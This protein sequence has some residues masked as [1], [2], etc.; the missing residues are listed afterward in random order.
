VADNGKGIPK[1]I[2]ERLGERGFTH[3]K[4]GGSGLGLYHAR[5][6]FALW[7]GSLS[8]KSS[9]GRGTTVEVRLPAA[10]P[11]LWFADKVE[12]LPGQVVV[13]L[14]DDKAIHATWDKL[15]TPFVSAGGEVVHF[16]EARLFRTWLSHHRNGRLLCLVDYEL[17]RQ[18]VSGLDVI[19]QEELSDRA[20][21]VTSRFTEPVILQRVSKLGL[22]M[23]PKGLVGQVPIIIQYVI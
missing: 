20:I 19:E 6:T 8:I 9:V 11:P 17:L 12:L 15:L 13:I 1:E 21:L 7:G 22:R 2:L 3:G 16:T 10:P 4:P 5:S 14:D 23:I 18:E